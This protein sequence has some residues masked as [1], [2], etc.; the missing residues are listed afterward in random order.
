MVE[1]RSAA[2]TGGQGEKEVPEGPKE[3]PDPRDPLARKEPSV[4]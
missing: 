3:P 1:R 4:S 2:C